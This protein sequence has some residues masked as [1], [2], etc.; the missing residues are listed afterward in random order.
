MIAGRW[1]LRRS[2]IASSTPS[3]AGRARGSGRSPASAGTSPSMN[4]WSSG[5]STN[6]GPNGGSTLVRSASSTSPAISPV[7]PAV[8][9]L[10]TSG[11]T[12]GTWSISC[13]DPG[14]GRQRTHARRTRG[15]RPTLRGEGSG[16]LVPRVD[17]RDVLLA[18]A[19]VDR[20][21]VPAGQ[22]EEVRYAVGLQPPRDYPTAVNLARG[23][24]V[25][26][27]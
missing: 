15:F 13:N 26:L 20:E 1:A 11:A 5:K 4:T 9:A 27:G 10:F 22:R 6:V 8:R 19:V 7:D 25:R 12:K 18:A 24:R 14:T 17:D 2:S 16:L 21:Q 23:G 3:G